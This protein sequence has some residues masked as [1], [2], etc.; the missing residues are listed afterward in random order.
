MEMVKN[1]PKVRHDCFQQYFDELSIDLRESIL[2]GLLRDGAENCDDHPGAAAV[3]PAD[4]VAD[5]VS[6]G[7]DAVQRSPVVALCHASG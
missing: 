4:G 3:R 5:S 2:A 6:V 7:Q 1:S